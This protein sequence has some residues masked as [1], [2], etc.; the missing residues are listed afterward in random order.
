[1][2]SAAS[3]NST[4][5]GELRDAKCQHELHLSIWRRFG[6]PPERFNLLLNKSELAF[7][8]LRPEFAESTYYLY[9][10]TKDPVYLQIGAMIV[11]NLDHYTRAKCGFATI[12]NVEDMTQE[13]RMESF[14]LSE[15]LKY[16][17]L[18]RAF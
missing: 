1:M 5:A 15:T 4:L 11:N 2:F 17:Y 10:A 14:F 9:R 7:Y 3:V 6:L 8:P 18:V 16:L 13:D 12:H